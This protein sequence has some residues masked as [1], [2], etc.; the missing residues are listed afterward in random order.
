MKL[1]NIQILRALAAA[2]VVYVHALSIYEA[3]V[4]ITS[5]N[6]I[7]G[8]SNLGDLGVKLFFCISGFIFLTAQHDC[9]VGFN[10]R[11]TFLSNASFV[12]SLYIMWQLQFMP[13]N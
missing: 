10:R 3:K 11:L 8:M 1:T 12:F 7:L 9:Q 6:P 4:G 5:D 13:L 2:F